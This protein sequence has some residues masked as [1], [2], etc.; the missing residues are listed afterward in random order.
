[1]AWTDEYAWIR[2]EDWR[3]VLRD[4][5]RLPSDIRA[6]LDAE[7]VYAD[8]VLAPTAELQ[9]ELFREMRGRLKED[10]SEPPQVDGPWAYYSRFLAGGQHPMYCRRPREG[11]EEVVLI[12]GDARAEDK[13][14][15]R[16]AATRHSPDHAKFAWS[17]DEVG[18]EMLTIRIRD[19]ERGEDLHDLIVNGAGD[20]VWTRDSKGLLYV[21][22]DESHRPFQV[23]LHRL[24]TDQSEDA[25]VYAEA[26]PAWFIGLE[27]TRLGR[28][29]FIVVYGHDASETHAVDLDRPTAKPLLIRP[30][31]PGLLYDVMDHGDCFYIRANSQARDFKV[32]VAP[33]DAPD[34]ANWRDVVSHR[35][36][37]FIANATL[38]RNFLV[39]LA[40]EDSCPR[41]TVYDLASGEAHDVAIDEEA[42]ALRLETVYEFDSRLLRFSLSSMKRSEEIIDYDCATRAGTLV[43]KREAPGFGPERYLTRLIFARAEDGESV[44]VSVLMKRDAE[45][46]GSSPLLLTAYGAYGHPV[47]ASFSTNRLSLVDRGFVYAVAHVRGGTEKGWRWYEEGKLLKKTNTF[48]DFLAAARHLIAERYTS[49]GRIVAHG[50]SAGGLLMGAVANLAPDLFAG[51]IADVPF[52][53]ALSTMLDASLPL[54]PPEWLEWGDPIRDRAAFEAI[55]SYSPYDNVR[56]QNYPAILALAG[57]TDPR[58][59]YWEPAK[60]VARLRAAM[61][62]G[63]PI[64]LRTAMEAG[65]AGRPGRF[66]RLEEVARNYAFAIACVSGGLSANRA[67]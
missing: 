49:A 58:V 5:A 22:Q 1:V 20:M 17:F 45:L 35:D 47:E 21:E 31:R 63:G 59:T 24:G 61:T 66:D 44:P 19:L 6:L 16:C 25:V 52:V 40:H 13:P 23:R 62:G 67:N 11:G 55:R 43:K 10:D 64:L 27:A 57:L 38:F 29:A 60:W 39:V 8:A 2:A 34:E 7:N 3:D 30:R 12:D 65:H 18:S 50:A 54:T 15:F 46:D 26:D 42:C 28:S 37:R 4:P 9:E 14:F 48:G 53:D 41:M 33:R 32:V 51:V 56:A 36:G